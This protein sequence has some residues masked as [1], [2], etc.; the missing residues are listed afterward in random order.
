MVQHATTQETVCQLLTSPE[1][2]AQPLRYSCNDMV[3]VDRIIEETYKME[4]YIDAQ[5][6]G[7]G[8]GW[9]RIVLTPEEAREQI[10]AGNMA[11]VLGIETSDLFDCFLTARGDAKRCTEADVVAKLDDYYAP[12]RESSVP[13]AQNG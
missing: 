8:E 3:A 2:G 1:I 5:S 12:G 9:F 7:P 4:R 13:G 11:V 6:G 10:R